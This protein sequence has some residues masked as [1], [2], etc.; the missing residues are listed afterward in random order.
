VPP[1]K[2]AARGESGSSQRDAAVDAYF[3][4]LDHPLKRDY[5]AARTILLGV[6]PEIRDGIKW[7][8]P[9]FRTHEWFA[10]LFV[11][12]RDAVQFIFHCGPK[13]KDG[14]TKMDVPDP[15]GLIRWVS[16]NRCFVTLGAGPE[17]AKRRAAFE[18][19]VRA[20][21]RQMPSP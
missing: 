16:T 20:W 18:S 6:S 4:G 2:R 11:R 15:D 5:E 10:T 17:I 21:I 1:R 9:S 7:N 12:S 3:A 14:A 8:G 19:I 13:A